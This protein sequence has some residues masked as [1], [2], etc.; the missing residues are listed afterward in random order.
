MNYRQMC[1]DCN[2]PKNFCL[3][4]Y[5]KP[6]DTVTKFIILM[7]PKE[8]KKIKNNTGR[9]THLSLKNSKLF[10]GVDFA[11]HKQINN[12]I[13]NP[14]NYCTIL[15]PGKNSICINEKNLKLYGRQLVVFIIDAT[16]DSSKPMLRLSTNLHKLPKI[17]F[18]HTKTSA[19][20]FKRQPFVEA[21]STIESTLAVLEALN[22]QGFENNLPLEYFLKPFE[23]LIKFQN[24]FTRNPRYSS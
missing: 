20:N 9:L 8:F 17:S 2:R 18:V 16:W 22:T 11:N 12:L 13:N 3:C 23:E 6:L 7:H 5:I 15:Y 4:Q 24:N 21:L 14:K 1:Y 10:V 19:Y